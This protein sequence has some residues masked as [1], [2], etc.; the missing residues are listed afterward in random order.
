M[1][2]EKYFNEYLKAKLVLNKLICQFYEYSVTQE[3]ADKLEIKYTEKDIFN[4]LNNV[5][6]VFHR[7]E[8]EGVYIWNKL[9]I[10]KPIILLSEMWKTQN[11]CERYN[12]TKNYYKEFL[13][14]KL[15][16]LYLSEKYYEFSISK[17]EADELGIIYCG[18]DNYDGKI[19]GC[20]HLFESA[21][22]NAWELFGF[23]EHFIPYSEF[24]KLRKE[25]INELLEMDIVKQKK[26]RM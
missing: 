2:N 24:R 1:E 25:L 6:C 11:L 19:Q 15:I 13:E 4:S 14:L 5:S 8:P 9:Q 23:E 17:E 22:E 21:G 7:Y 12:E 18:I 26:L 16:D 20:D 3:Q 10:E